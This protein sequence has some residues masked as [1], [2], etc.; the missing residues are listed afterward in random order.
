[1]YVCISMYVCMYKYVY[2]YIYIY[3]LS[4]SKR[5]N[6]SAYVSSR[7][8]NHSS[9]W[10]LHNLLTVSHSGLNDFTCAVTE[11]VARVCL[12]RMLASGKGVACRA[13]LPPPLSLKVFWL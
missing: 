8:G 7:K 6:G 4:S 1:M 5:H 3:A 13:Y 11:T 2:I 12:Q 10:K 9:D